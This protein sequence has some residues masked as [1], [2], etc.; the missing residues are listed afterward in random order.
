MNKFT[1]FFDAYHFLRDHEMVKHNKVSQ[2]ERCLD[3]SV[4]KINPETDM[5]DE[6]DENNTKTQ[7]WLEF[8]PYNSEENCV[9]HDYNLDCC[10]DTVEEGI[11]KLADL[12]KLHYRDNGEERKLPAI[13]IETKHYKL[14][15]TNLILTDNTVFDEYGR[16]LGSNYTVFDNHTFEPVNMEEINIYEFEWQEIKE[17]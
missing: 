6:Y 9:V 11:I 14:L 1:D 15:G 7:V 17:A 10:A 13:K 3:I 12:V 4:V 5:I 8:G 16:E 2:F